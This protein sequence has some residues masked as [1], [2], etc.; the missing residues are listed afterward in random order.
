VI[1][2][3]TG[4]EAVEGRPAEDDPDH[5]R[6]HPLGA[7]DDGNPCRRPLAGHLLLCR[8]SG[9][10]YGVGDAGIRAKASRQKKVAHAKIIC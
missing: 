5:L 10:G 7:L 4:L 3:R 9:G 2:E 6:S 1:G 8:H